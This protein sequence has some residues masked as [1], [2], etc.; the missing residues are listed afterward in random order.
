MC[1][2]HTWIHTQTHRNMH[3]QRTNVKNVDLLLALPTP[4]DHTCLERETTGAAQQDVCYFKLSIVNIKATQIEHKTFRFIYQLLLFIFYTFMWL[5]NLF[6]SKSI[7][8][9]KPTSAGSCTYFTK[10]GADS[11][12]VFIQACTFVQVVSIVLWSKQAIHLNKIVRLS[13]LRWYLHLF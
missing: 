5:N 2:Q 13:N 3:T 11:N 6:S 12:S 8:S 4:R 10:E 7:N 1:L 9:L